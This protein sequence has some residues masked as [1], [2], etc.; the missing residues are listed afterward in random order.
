VLASSALED[1]GGYDV[2]ELVAPS[3]S[4]FL[5]PRAHGRV[6]PARRWWGLPIAR[7]VAVEEFPE[8]GM[9]LI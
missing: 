4:R 9:R 5:I 2:D 6:W 8:E 7:T 3:A 1:C